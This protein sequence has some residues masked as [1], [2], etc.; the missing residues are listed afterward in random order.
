MKQMLKYKQ[1]SYSLLGVLLSV[2]FMQC[3]ETSEPSGEADSISI[4]AEGIELK[5]TDIRFYNGVVPANGHSFSIKVVSP[6][7]HWIGITGVVNGK[8]YFMM[9]ENEESLEEEWGSIR[10][11]SNS[12]PFEFDVVIGPNSS[13]E[14]R[15]ITIDLQ[16]GNSF[17]TLKLTQL[18]E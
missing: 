15:V 18:A 12:H 13:N 14:D 1:L 6:Y 4:E 16:C 17:G 9:E 10:Y 5:N 11:V 7:C 3:G 2:L 8:D